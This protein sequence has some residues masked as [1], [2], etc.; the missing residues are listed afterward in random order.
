MSSASGST[1]SS[2]RKS[3]KELQT[4]KKNKATSSHNEYAEIEES[5][6]SPI[7]IHDEDS[8]NDN[9][10]LSSTSASTLVPTPT[11][12]STPAL[13]STPAPISIPAPIP[14]PTPNTPDNIQE[15]LP[16]IN[17]KNVKL[18]LIPNAPPPGNSWIW[19]YFDQYVPIPSYKRI[20]RC[21]VEIQ[22]EDGIKECGHMIGT[23]GSTGNCISHLAKH[24]IRS[25]ERRVG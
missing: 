3:K 23:D 12:I 1:R 2:K 8:L 25:E 15:Q 20:V 21:L 16:K 10:S 22:G 4:N 24:S 13:I 9:D 18:T 19:P 14:T 17:L 5:C 6:L 7:T 11:P